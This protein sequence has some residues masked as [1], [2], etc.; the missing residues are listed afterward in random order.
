MPPA[1]V[2]LQACGCQSHRVCCGLQKPPAG[3]APL[4]STY[5]LF[6]RPLQSFGP[7]CR[8]PDALP[9]SHPDHTGGGAALSAREGISIFSKALPCCVPTGGKQP[10]GP[11]RLLPD[12]V[13]RATE[14]N[15]SHVVRASFSFKETHGSGEQLTD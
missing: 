4:C 9:G 2:L 14:I 10:L 7:C 13:F 8:L 3:S 15:E 12:T 6:L 5:L 1:A 11:A